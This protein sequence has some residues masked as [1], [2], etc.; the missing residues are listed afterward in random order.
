MDS[1]ACGD[2]FDVPLRLLTIMT[3][4]GQGSSFV[5]IT[6]GPRRCGCVGLDL[7]AGEKYNEEGIVRLESSRALA[8]HSAADRILAADSALLCSALHIHQLQPGIITARQQ[9]QTTSPSSISNPNEPCSTGP[10]YPRFPRISRNRPAQAMA[11]TCR[12][13]WCVYSFNRCPASALPADRRVASL[14]ATKRQRQVIPRIFYASSITTRSPQSPSL[15]SLTPS[16]STCPYATSTCISLNRTCTGTRRLGP[17]GHP[18]SAA[19]LP[20]SPS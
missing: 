5:S 12:S 8:P 15:F 17:D 11:T 13:R 7:Y 19:D 1:P 10:G 2:I 16:L 3:C 14:P 18:N 9:L 20:S 6:L 4:G